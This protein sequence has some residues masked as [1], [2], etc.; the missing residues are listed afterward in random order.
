MKLACQA[1]IMLAA[2]ASFGA[3]AQST[4]NCPSLPANAGLHWE[5]LDGPGFLFCKALGDDGRESFAVTVSHDSP[6]KPSRGNRA[7]ENSIAGQPGRW[8]RSEI[9]TDAGAL[10]RETLIKLDSG[11]VAHISFRADSEAQ[12]Q[13]TMQQVSGMRFSA[14]QRLSSN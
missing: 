3:L 13:D 4:P 6:F 7:E 1:A 8:Y 11:Q 14:D 5:K 12:M 10:A 9:A 2:L